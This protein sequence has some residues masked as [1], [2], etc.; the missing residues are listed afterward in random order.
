MLA[1]AAVHG[2]V[3]PE[4][5]LPLLQPRTVA[6]KSPMAVARRL[7]TATCV[8]MT[9]PCELASFAAEGADKPDKALGRQ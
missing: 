7:R 5:E 6:N 2:M 3:P 8:T 9:D 1:V 4:V